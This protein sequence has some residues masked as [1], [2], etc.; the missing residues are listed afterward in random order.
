MKEMIIK[1]HNDE[2]VR[3]VY[4]KAAIALAMIVTVIM[5]VFLGIIPLIKYSGRP[6]FLDILVTPV[7]AIVTVNNKEMRNAV[8]EME[9][10]KYTATIAREG[11]ET[12][13]MDLDLEKDKTTGIYLSLAPD[14][15][16]WGF[17][18]EIKNKQ[19]LDVLL[20]L[21]NVDT[22]GKLWEPA[23]KVTQEN[24]AAENLAN[25]FKIKAITP[26]Y[27]SICGTPANRMN[28]NAIHVEYEYS[29]KCGD[30]LCLVVKGRTKELNN[31]AWDEVRAELLQNGYSLDDYKYIYVWD[32]EL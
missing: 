6:A 29:K 17:Y 7:D 19:S 2:Y 11:F 15:G 16:D 1:M 14:D 21:N 22:D 32:A 20:R 13:V 10:G 26:I 24:S 12:V 27:I 18:E 31:E 23:L 4:I 9:P 30:K 25:K 8:Y 28:C 5:I 3:K